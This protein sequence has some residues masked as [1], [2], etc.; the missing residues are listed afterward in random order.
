MYLIITLHGDIYL[1]RRTASALLVGSYCGY[2]LAAVRLTALF[3]NLYS[4]CN[5]IYE[6]VVVPR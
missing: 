3:N 1:L 4:V 2:G 5:V 6:L